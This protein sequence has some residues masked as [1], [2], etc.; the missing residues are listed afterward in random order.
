[1]TAS[2]RFLRRYK[3]SGNAYAHRAIAIDHLS[4]S[5]DT[6]RIADEMMAC[7]T[8]VDA[9][10]HPFRCGHI[11]CP[12]CAK[13]RAKT[14]S[15]RAI[16][17]FRSIPKEHIGFATIVF[18]AHKDLLRLPRHLGVHDIFTGGKAPD[19]DAACLAMRSALTHLK[20]K[21]RHTFKPPS[22]EGFVLNG[23]FEF[24]SKPVSREKSNTAQFS[25]GSLDLQHVLMPPNG[26]YLVHTH[27]HFLIAADIDA[28]RATLDEL[29]HVLRQAFPLPGQVKLMPLR[30]TQEKNTAVARCASY[31]VKGHVGDVPPE[32]ARQVAL[33]YD[34]IGNRFFGFE[35]TGGA[36]QA[37]RADKASETD[38]VRLVESRCAA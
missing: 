17:A 16:D 15:N 22:F 20:R 3:M 8:L 26:F 14:K 31:C 12:D 37:R 9:R 29:R 23:A 24:E 10:R 7:G 33:A 18:E 30:A 13:H 4:G 21:L 34:R 2:K 11:Y 36:L 5:P 35:W 1:M 19:P 28:R 32:N 27:C 25:A 38:E 6:A